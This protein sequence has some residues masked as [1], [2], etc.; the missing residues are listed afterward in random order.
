[1]DLTVLGVG[2][3]ATGCVTVLLIQ[4]ERFKAAL[5]TLGLAAVFMLGIPDATVG[6]GNSKVARFYLITLV[7]AIGVSVLLDSAK[8]LRAWVI[9]QIFL[10]VLLST[11]A[12][13]SP[14]VSANVV[15]A[16]SIEGS[17]TIAAGRAAGVAF[18]GLLLLAITSRGTTLCRLTLAVGGL[19][20][21]YP[22]INSGSRGPVAAAVTAVAVGAVLAPAVAIRRITRVSLIVIALITGFYILR[23]DSSGG[24]QRV[25]STLF[26]GDFADNSSTTRFTLWR[27]SFDFI[28]SHP[29]GGGWGAF[30]APHDQFLLLGTNGLN[31]PHDLL[32][33]TT[34]EAGW[35]AGV[36]LIVFVCSALRKMQRAAQYP[37]MAAMFGI[38][39]FSLINSLVS[40]DVNDRLVWASLAAAWA[41]PA[42]WTNQRDLSERALATTPS[43][44]SQMTAG[45]LAPISGLNAPVKP[46]SASTRRVK[47]TAAEPAPVGQAN[48]VGR[49]GGTNAVS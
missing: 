39:I 24:A 13:L 41:I 23:G 25:T 19:A 28:M 3:T 42:V 7:V 45:S 2:L 17:T 47:P 37:Y 8:R 9:V 1:M 49:V 18:V 40:G 29:F 16:L 33:E 31:Y 34:G 6:Y 15:G 43:Q 38:A 48:H 32:L 36:T 20:A 35:I 44:S 4:P 11:S 21:V 12:V 27:D 5:P 30:S 26:A 22:L 46:A 14:P 10:G